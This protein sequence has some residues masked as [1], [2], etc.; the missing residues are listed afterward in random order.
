[1]KILS[2][3]AAILALSMVSAC[4]AP[5]GPVEVTRFHVLDTASLGQG[6]ISVE[7][8][9][10]QQAQDLEFR[11]YAAAVSRELTRL[12]YSVF[13]PGGEPSRTAAT[14]SVERLVVRPARDGGPV[15]IGVGGTTGSY[16]SGVG[17]GIGL[18]LSGPPPE[19]IE[20]RISVRIRDR[21]SKETLWEGRASFLARASSPLAQS[22]LGAAK[23]AEALFQDFPGQS[24]ETILIE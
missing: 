2:C 17:V 11:T 9:E 8:A 16:G 3:A 19:S 23:M 20:T 4:V 13:T 14:L 24:G 15:S 18:D 22:Q 12:G 10:G 1:M 5:V 21:Q 7:A 6:S